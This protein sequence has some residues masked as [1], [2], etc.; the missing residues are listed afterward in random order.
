M[1]RNR[2]INDDRNAGIFEDVLESVS[3]DTLKSLEGDFSSDSEFD[4]SVRSI[5]AHERI[6]RKMLTRIV[7]KF[8]KLKDGSIR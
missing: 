6:A 8:K 1:R 3:E 7:E 4:K 5:I 2:K